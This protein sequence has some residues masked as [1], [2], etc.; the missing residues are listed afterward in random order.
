MHD[1]LLKNM[2][3]I[4]FPESSN[5]C[6]IIESYAYTSGCPKNVFQF[7][8][9]QKFD[10]DCFSL[11]SFFNDLKIFIKVMKGLFSVLEVKEH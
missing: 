6:E 2:V 10:D 4:Y 9:L 3:S 7:Q 8:G 1:H 11:I 5:D